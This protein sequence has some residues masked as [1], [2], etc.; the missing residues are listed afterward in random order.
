MITALLLGVI[1]SFAIAIYNFF[2]TAFNFVFSNIS[3]AFNILSSWQGFKVGIGII[4]IAIGYNWLLQNITI[5]LSILITVKLG[6]LLI[7]L[8]T[9]GGN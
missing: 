5:F 9:K 1:K 4:D 6:Q 8:L 2:V 3:D 7:G